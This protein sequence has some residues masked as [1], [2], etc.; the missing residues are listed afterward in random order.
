MRTHWSEADLAVLKD[1]YAKGVGVKS[2]ATSLGRS[3]SAVRNRAKKLGITMP[4][5]LGGQ[6]VDCGTEISRH[7]KLCKDCRRVFRAKDEAKRRAASPPKPKPRKAAGKTQVQPV[8]GSGSETQA[9]PPG[10]R[11]R[12]DHRILCAMGRGARLPVGF[13]TAWASRTGRPSAMPRASPRHRWFAVATASRIAK[14]TCG[15]PIEKPGS[16]GRPQTRRK[17]MS[18]TN[19]GDSPI[20]DTEGFVYHNDMFTPP[21]IKAFVRVTMKNGYV[22][23]VRRNAVAAAMSQTIG[24][25]ECAVSFDNGIGIVISEGAESFIGRCALPVLEDDDDA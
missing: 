14:P 2:L 6:C 17:P 10:T 8:E 12:G 7:G 13:S 11:A 5:G 21:S 24:D 3:Y 4:K 23:F 1:G 22:G 16:R 9:A 15:A 19:D 25:T 20:Q 18:E